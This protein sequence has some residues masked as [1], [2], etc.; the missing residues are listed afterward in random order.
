MMHCGISARCIVGF[1]QQIHRYPIASHEV[2]SLTCVVSLSL[3]SAMQCHVKLLHVYDLQISFIGMIVKLRNIYLDFHFKLLL[4]CAPC[5]HIIV[6][7][8]AS[9]IRVKYKF[10]VW[11]IL[12]LSVDVKNNRCACWWI[13]MLCIVL[14]ETENSIVLVIFLNI[15]W[16]VKFLD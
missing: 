11:K 2:Q 10:N 14:L 8:T 5:A 7:G 13:L 6:N 1:V 4:T 9:E 3:L 16:E 15:T 12:L